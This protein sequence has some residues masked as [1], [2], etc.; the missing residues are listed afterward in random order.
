MQVAVAVPLS[1]ELVLAAWVEMV[2]AA[3]VATIRQTVLAAQGQ[4]IPA[5]EAV[6]ELA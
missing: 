1:Q 5:G 4:P 6:P 3:T 2:G